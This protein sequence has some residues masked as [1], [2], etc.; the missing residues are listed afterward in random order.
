MNKNIPKQII[1]Y[2]LI[3]YIVKQQRLQMLSDNSGI[4]N[5]SSSILE[6]CKLKALIVEVLSFRNIYNTNNACDRFQVINRHVS[7]SIL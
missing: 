6:S 7:F 1:S 2:M 4:Y 3:S 5:Q